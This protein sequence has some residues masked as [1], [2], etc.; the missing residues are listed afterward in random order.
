M[1]IH[2]FIY[3]I[4]ML[5]IIIHDRIITCPNSNISTSCWETSLRCTLITWSVPFC[6]VLLQRKLPCYYHRHDQHQACRRALGREGAHH[7]ESGFRQPEWWPWKDS[8]ALGGR[9]LNFWNVAGPPWV[10]VST[11]SSIQ[12]QFL[13]R[14]EEIREGSLCTPALY[15]LAS[16]KGMHPV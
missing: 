10:T 5:I 3:N 4:V 8:A 16:F 12:V 14:P 7:P 6:S 9:A 15:L 1:C 11:S 2:T 13:W